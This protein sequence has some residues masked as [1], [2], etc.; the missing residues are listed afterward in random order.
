MSVYLPKFMHYCLSRHVFLY[1]SR[2]MSLHLPDNM[3]YNLRKFLS[4]AMHR[5]LFW[6]VWF[7]LRLWMYGDCI[8]VL[9]R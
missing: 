2:C 1:L 9:K 6:L 7:Q 5:H 4:T 3:Y 8:I